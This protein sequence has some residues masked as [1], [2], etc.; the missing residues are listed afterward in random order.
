MSLIV[1]KPFTKP[2]T[3][4]IIAA[5]QTD[6]QTFITSS[7]F[8]ARVRFIASFIH[9]LSFLNFRMAA[10]RSSPFLFVLYSTLK[11]SFRVHEC[12]LFSLWEL[13]SDRRKREGCLQKEEETMRGKMKAFRFHYGH[14]T[15]LFS[16]F[17]TIPFLHNNSFFLALIFLPVAQAQF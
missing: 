7:R 9:V 4:H 13:C 10:R 1:R 8:V 17:Y 11:A 16:A 6:R 15:L 14:W 5:T 12:T 3:R 2:A